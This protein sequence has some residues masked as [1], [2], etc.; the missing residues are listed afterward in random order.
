ML[1]HFVRKDTIGWSIHGEANAA[2]VFDRPGTHRRSAGRM[3][4]Q[5]ASYLRRL[6]LWISQAASVSWLD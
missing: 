3:A 5:R 6:P 4:V 1:L 2:D